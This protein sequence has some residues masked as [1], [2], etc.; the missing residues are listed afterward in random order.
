MSGPSAQ[1]KSVGIRAQNQ[2]AIIAPGQCI[3]PAQVQWQHPHISWHQ[4]QVQWGIIPAPSPGQVAIKAQFFFS[5]S[6]QVPHSGIA[7]P[8]S[9]WQ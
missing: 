3:S 8:R 1:P 9:S 6:A 5:A 2:V 4:A 7:Q